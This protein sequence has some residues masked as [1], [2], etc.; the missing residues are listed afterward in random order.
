MGFELVTELVLL[1]GSEAL[2]GIDKIFVVSVLDRVLAEFE[3]SLAAGSILEVFLVV[4]D[5]ALLL[6]DGLIVVVSE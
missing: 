5:E 3:L 2:I 6:F 4:L 1:F